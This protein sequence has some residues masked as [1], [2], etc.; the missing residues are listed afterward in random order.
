MTVYH[1]F[2]DDAGESHLRPIDLHLI[3]ATG[4]GAGR[5]RV[6]G[7]FPA[8]DVSIGETLD[9]LE[10]QGLHPPPRRQF[11]A[12]LAGNYEIETTSGDKVRLAPG[13]CLFVDDAGG[14]GHWCRDVGDDSLTILSAGIPD[15]FVYP[16]VS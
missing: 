12:I 16:P 13:D 2:A 9:R 3:D 8:Y 6:L 14:K 15:D 5:V 7:G 11:L 1:L 10:D 4:Q